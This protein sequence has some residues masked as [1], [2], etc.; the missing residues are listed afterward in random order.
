MIINLSAGYIYSAIFI[1]S[2]QKRTAMTNELLAY[3]ISAI[4]GILLL[5]WCYGMIKYAIIPHKEKIYTLTKDLS[6]C[7]LQ[8]IFVVM[9]I[10][11]A[12]YVSS[13]IFRGCT[14][15]DPEKL[16]Y[17]YDRRV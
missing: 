9:L 17:D 7:L 11:G 16:H 2:L 10:I 15:T 13:Y 3:G 8:I 12:L 5:Y 1:L 14:P 6:G 4:V